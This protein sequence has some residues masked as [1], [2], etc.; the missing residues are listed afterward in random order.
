[1]K[2]AIASNENHVK[3]IIDQHFGRCD[4]FCLYD[5]TTEE[6]KFIENPVRHHQEK[7]GCDAADLLME[8]GISMVIAGRFGSKVVEVFRSKNIQM[9]IPENQQTINDIINQLKSKV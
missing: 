8:K 7:A 2:I 1:M 5:T 3:S 4:W 6:T 9:I